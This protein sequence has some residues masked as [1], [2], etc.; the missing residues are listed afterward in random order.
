MKEGKP[1][2]GKVK[3]PPPPTVIKAPAGAPHVVVV[4]IDAFGSSR[5]IGGADFPI[6]WERKR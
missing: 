6:D 3:A 4:L 5:D 2:T 1:D